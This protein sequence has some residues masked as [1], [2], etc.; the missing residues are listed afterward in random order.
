M[1]FFEALSQQGESLTRWP[2]AIAGGVVTDQLAQINLNFSA[3]LC[4]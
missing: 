3:S 4:G 2:S 1:K